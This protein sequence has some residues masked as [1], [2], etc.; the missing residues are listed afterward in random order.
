[1]KKIFI[2]FMFLPALLSC[3]GKDTGMTRKAIETVDRFCGEYRTTSLETLDGKIDLD[4][5]GIRSNDL[6]SEMERTGWLGYSSPFD[7]LLSLVAPK[8]EKDRTASIRLYFPVGAFG[9]KPDIP[10]TVRMESVQFAYDVDDEGTITAPVGK[11]INADG[12]YDYNSIK[13]VSFEVL[14][15]WDLELTGTIYLYDRSD[16]EFVYRKVRAI[17]HCVSTKQKTKE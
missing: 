12:Q 3:S 16:D 9:K 5:D 8:T 17:Y 14:D 1:M 4:G 10:Q 11:F 15:N 7:E 13:D 6:R 2:L